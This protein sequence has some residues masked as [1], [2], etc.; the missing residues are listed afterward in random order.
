MRKLFTLM[1]TG[2]LALGVAGVA[3]AALLNWS[4]T[5]TTT[6]ADFPATSIYGGGVATVN[7]SSG[8]L[9]AHLNSRRLAE[10]RGQIRGTFTRIVT[11]PDTL[12]NGVAAII[13]DNVRGG[14][15]TVSNI[16]GGAA[17]TG[18]GGGTL[19]IL[20]VIKICLLSTAC[21]QFLP[22]PLGQ[23][24]TVNGVPGTGFKGP[25]VGGLVTAGGYGGIRI[26]VQ[27]AP[28]TIKTATVLDQ[29]TTTTGTPPK[30]TRIFITKTAQGWAH[31]PASE[32]SSTAQIG[33]VV[34]LVTPQ[35]T[36]TNLPLGSN[37]KQGAFTVSV[38]E[39]IPEPGLVLL[40]ASGVAGLALLGRSRMRK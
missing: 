14:T 25:G 28:W 32:T 26:S 1:T 29:I 21:T 30:Q 35:Q 36:T 27:G 12:A 31:A 6:L 2:L 38:I 16:S 4:G 17:S 9:P 39:F 11:D 5:S 8:V 23:P 13:Y 34:Q 3:N 37:A 7:G 20:G 10:S 19:P 40:L 33:G 22:I 24:T 15:G 18:P